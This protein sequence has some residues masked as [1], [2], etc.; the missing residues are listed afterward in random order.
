MSG[1]CRAEYEVLLV[2]GGLFDLY[3]VENRRDVL[4]GLQSW[5]HRPSRTEQTL[6]WLRLLKPSPIKLG[7]DGLDGVTVKS[8]LRTLGQVLTRVKAA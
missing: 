1:L 5:R 2:S 7:V 8:A 4:E 3:D 6:K